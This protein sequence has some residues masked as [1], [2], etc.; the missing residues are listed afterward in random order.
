MT[1]YRRHTGTGAVLKVP[2]SV[3]SGPKIL[4]PPYG[5]STTDE[6]LPHHP[7]AAKGL[8]PRLVVVQ[9]TPAIFV[10]QALS[11]HLLLEAATTAMLATCEEEAAHPSERGEEADP[12]SEDILQG[13]ACRHQEGI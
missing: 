4:P 11:L 8:V 10:I 1:E 9:L 13:E 12:L 3:F 2:A 5:A 6:V 7:R